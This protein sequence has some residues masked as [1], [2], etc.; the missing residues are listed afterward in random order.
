RSLRRRRVG[1]KNERGGCRRG[2]PGHHGTE[3]AGTMG[4]IRTRSIAGMA[5]AMALISIAGGA[6]PPAKAPARG[7]SAASASATAS[8]RVVPDDDAT[9]RPT[10]IVRK[11][12]SQ[13]SGTVIASV[14]GET[15]IL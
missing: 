1:D 6:G 8:R 7:T 12:N 2:G 9:F 3:R 10:V 13:G 14:D 4:E 15:L 5:L 11:G